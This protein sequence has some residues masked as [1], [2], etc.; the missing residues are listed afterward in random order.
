MGQH[1]RMKKISDSEFTIRNGSD[2]WTITIEN[3]SGFYTK[4]N[5]VS[6]ERQ[7]VKCE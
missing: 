4:K 6:I 7:P 3:E 1:G 5:D 2:K